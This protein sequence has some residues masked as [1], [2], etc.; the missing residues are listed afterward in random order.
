MPGSLSATILPPAPSPTS[1]SRLV[2]IAA[3][4]RFLS[5]HPLCQVRPGLVP[6]N[7]AGAPRAERHADVWLGTTGCP[8]QECLSQVGSAAGQLQHWSPFTEGAVPHLYRCP[9]EKP[10]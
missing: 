2:G 5:Q 7:T 9:F 3:G 8:H 4:T 1:V 6:V 10:G